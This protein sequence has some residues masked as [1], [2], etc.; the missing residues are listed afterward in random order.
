MIVPNRTAVSTA[1]R[2]GFNGKEKDDELKGGGNSLDFGAR[3]YDSRI[4][5]WFAK[6]P[7]LQPYESPYNYAANNPIFYIDNDGEDN[8]VYLVLLP[9]AKE[10]LGKKGM[11]SLQKETQKRLKDLGLKTEVKIFEDGGSNFDSRN[12]D[13][14]DSFVVLGSLS[15]IKKEVKGSPRYADLND[16]SEGSSTIDGFQGV[17]D[18]GVEDNPERSAQKTSPDE[19]KSGKIEFASGVLVDIKVTEERTAKYNLLTTKETSFA[20]F[21]IHG[22]GHNAGLQHDSTVGY[23]NA[24]YGNLSRSVGRTKNREID[25]MKTIEDVFN[26]TNNN[27]FIKA[28]RK[29]LNDQ[30]DVKPTDN[31]QKNKSDRSAKA[32]KGK[33]GK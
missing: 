3:I 25:L 17:S 7:V 8:I 5:R 13:K 23:L 2:Y 29:R 4:G 18:Y 28:L 11:V 9:S 31:Y 20:Y 10:K 21:A 16:K 32:N 15:E 12:L 22:L 19:F 6:D 33:K 26:K 30:K 1:Y 27:G 24:D 14:S